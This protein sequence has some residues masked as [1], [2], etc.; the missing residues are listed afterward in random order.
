MGR[1]PAAVLRVPQDLVYAQVVKHRRG[2]R[3]KKVE[4]RPIFGKTK[5]PQVV[6]AL[7]WK[8]ANTSA[9]ERRARP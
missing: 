7:E 2:G 9:L 8:Q 4:I 5:L 1:P 6:A 3:V